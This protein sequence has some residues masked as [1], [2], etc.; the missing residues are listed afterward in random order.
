M[1]AHSES[2]RGLHILVRQRQ[3]EDGLEAH[4]LVW[5]IMQCICRVCTFRGACSWGDRQ[6]SPNCI[7]PLLEHI[8]KSGAATMSVG[9]LH[10]CQ[11]CTSEHALP[12]IKT[13]P[14]CE[15]PLLDASKHCSWTVSSILISHYKLQSNPHNTQSYRLTYQ[16]VL[17]NIKWVLYQ[18]I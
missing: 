16:Q 13:M 4:W 1:T 3:P 8:V 14:N 11:M 10:R 5:Q 2:E 18:H 6:I 17:A 9:H 15:H 7:I 12:Y